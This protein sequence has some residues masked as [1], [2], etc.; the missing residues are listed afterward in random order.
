MGRKSWGIFHQSQ[1]LTGSG[2]LLTHQL[3]LPCFQTEHTLI[4]IW[5]L[6]TKRHTESYLY[7]WKPVTSKEGQGIWAEHHKMEHILYMFIKS[8]SNLLCSGMANS[9]IFQVGC[10]GK[11]CPFLAAY[12]LTASSWD[13][14]LCNIIFYKKNR[15]IIQPPLWQGLLRRAWE[16]SNMQLEGPMVILSR[17]MSFGMEVYG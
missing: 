14:Q 17:N 1:S 12:S 3:A 4:A 7:A 16:G 13:N 10:A 9:V 8:W 11:I 2:L 6:S 5:M 15:K